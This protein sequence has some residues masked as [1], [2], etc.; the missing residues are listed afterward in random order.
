MIRPTVPA[1]PNALGLVPASPPP[2][3][4]GLAPNPTTTAWCKKCSGPTEHTRSGQQ[5]D[6]LE[7][8][9]CHTQRVD[10]KERDEQLPFPVPDAKGVGSTDTLEGK[11]LSNP[12]TPETET[13]GVETIRLKLPWPK[14]PLT[15]NAREHWRV[16]AQ[17]TAAV[18]ETVRLVARP[19]GVALAHPIASEVE[20]ELRWVVTDKRRR[21]VDNVTASLKPC[22]DG[23]R[24]AGVL[25]DDHSGIVVKAYCSIELGPVKSVVLIVRP[26]TRRSLRLCDCGRVAEP[27]TPKCWRCS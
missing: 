12:E 6:T 16:K 13:Q 18:R 2:L 25:A 19:D 14:P 10:R 15:L 7:C 27:G 24:D 22:M 8:T 4:V 9:N 1:S 20:V 5:L 3:R 17:K 23:L 11:G 21:D 26:V